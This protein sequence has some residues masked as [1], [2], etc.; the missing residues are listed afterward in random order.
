MATKTD[1]AK[2]ETPRLRTK[3][4]TSDPDKVLG[5]D[6]DP[7]INAYLEHSLSDGS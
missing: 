6:L 4:E 5:G 1:A 2:L 7:L 3:Y